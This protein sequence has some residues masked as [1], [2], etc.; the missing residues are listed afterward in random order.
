MKNLF[1]L[2]LLS[3]VLFSCTKE[4]QIDIPGYKENLVI[5]G[6]IETGQP[7]IVLLSTTNN[8]YSPTNLD[9]YLEGFISGATIIVSDGTITDTL[10][11]IC[12]DELPAGTE[13]IAAAFF[14]IPVEQLVQLH[15]CAYIS[16][17]I[18]GEVGKT[19]SLKVIHEGKT[20]T[21]STT[22]YPPKSLDSL[23]WKPQNGT[24]EYGFS[25]AILSDETATTDAYKWETKYVSEIVFNKPFNPF[26]NDK[27]FNGL[28]FEFAY[29]NP[30]SY[31]DETYPEDFRGYY[32]VG[33]TVVI[34]FSKIGS[35]EYNFFEKKY[36]QIYSSG[37]PF[38]TPTNIPTNIVGGAFG[39]WV[40]YSPAYDTL[41]CKL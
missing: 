24:T 7:A 28:T 25:W 23:Y 19:Y 20:Y 37:N 27:F 26:F 39:V 6:N 4:V 16:T 12:T 2:L 40:G 21:S 18:V 3:I 22:I 36:N 30:M 8:I 33:D 34:K 13:E 10:T 31:G 29:D 15:L 1:Y 9:A 32:R 41:I 11:E 14:G 35:K 5:D 38:A 17:D